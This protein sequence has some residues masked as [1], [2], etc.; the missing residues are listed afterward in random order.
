MILIKNRQRTYDIDTTK[1][2]SDAQCIL[3]ELRYSDFDLGILITSDKTI[4]KYNRDYRGKDKPTDILSFPHHPHIKAGERIIAH[5]EDDKNLGDIILSPSFIYNDLERWG[6]SF[7]HRLEDL[8]VH[9]ICHLLGYDHIEDSD[10]KIMRK[11]EIAL[12]KKL[13]SQKS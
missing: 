7:E 9:G 13:R 4:R 6:V 2:I 3:N 10:Y 5:N 11:K 12:L 8:L 1:M